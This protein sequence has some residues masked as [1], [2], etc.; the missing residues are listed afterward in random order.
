LEFGDS[1][2]NAV[3]CNKSSL[4]LVELNIMSSCTRIQGMLMVYQVVKKLI[5]ELFVEIGDIVGCKCR[6]MY[7]TL[8]AVRH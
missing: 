5:M 2:L 6:L 8:L 1:T 7:F 3:E 4:F